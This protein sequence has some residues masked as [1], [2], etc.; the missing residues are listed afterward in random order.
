[1]GIMS[2]WKRAREGK[3]E[4]ATQRA[5]AQ[6]AELQENMAIREAT[7]AKTRKEA[8]AQRAELETKAKY[9]RGGFFKKEITTTSRVVGTGKNKRTI[10]SHGLGKSGIQKFAE[11]A[12]ES[13]REEAVRQPVRRVPME[14][15][16]QEQPDMF[17]DMFRQP[18]ESK[19]RR[20]EDS[21]LR[22]AED[23]FGFGQ[24]QHRKGKKKKEEFRF[25]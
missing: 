10:T 6:R 13:R 20:R 8:I 12:A 11:R 1:M 3:K 22:S 17:G 14:R 25:I 7:I 18:P 4:E 15:E 9:N 2:E 5:I 23:M 24:P 19:Q 21:G 16:R